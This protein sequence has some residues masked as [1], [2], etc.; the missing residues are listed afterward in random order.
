MYSVMAGLVPAIHVFREA[1]K[2]WMPGTRPGMTQIWPTHQNGNNGLAV[3]DVGA[4]DLV[5]GGKIVRPR[6]R[7][8]RHHAAEVRAVLAAAVYVRVHALGRNRQPLERF[9]RKPLLQRLLERL[10]A[11]DAVRARAGDGDADLGAALGGEHADQREA[12]CL[13]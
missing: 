4:L 5:P 7:A 3:A 6:D 13:G 12:P 2:T 1:S 10:H 8:A 9:R 11:E